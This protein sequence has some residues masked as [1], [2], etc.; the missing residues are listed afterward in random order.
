MSSFITRS[1]GRKRPQNCDTACFMDSE[2]AL[3]RNTIKELL[4]LWIQQ[5]FKAFYFPFCKAD[6]S[7]QKQTSSWLDKITDLESIKV[8][9]AL[10]QTTESKSNGIRTLWGYLYQER[11]DYSNYLRGHTFLKK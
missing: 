5:Y 11:P 9:V 2:G 1:F 3:K 7:S 6:T 4:Q 10:R 8:Q